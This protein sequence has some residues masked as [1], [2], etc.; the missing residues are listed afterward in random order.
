MAVVDNGILKTYF[1]QGDIPTEQQ[2]INLI[3]SKAHVDDLGLYD[4]SVSDLAAGR[5][6]YSDGTEI[7]QSNNLF[8]DSTNDRLGLGLNA[9]LLGR[10]HSRAPGNLSSDIAGIFT[11]VAANIIARF[12]GD[13]VT[14]LYRVNGLGTGDSLGIGADPLGSNYR[15]WLG[16]T[17]GGIYISAPDSGINLDITAGNGNG[18]FTTCSG[19]GGTAIGFRALVNGVGAGVRYGSLMNVSGGATGS[20][21][22]FYGQNGSLQLDAND[23]IINDDTKGLVLKSPDGHYWRVKVD[24]AGALNTTDLG[25]TINF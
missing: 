19:A 11:N 23:A 17:S 22:A 25:T 24:N 13:R 7:T 4:G 20:N 8:W 14:E 21:I 10:L 2:F 15:V 9:S 5:I 3:D 1:E 6:P 12:R 18:I 16:G